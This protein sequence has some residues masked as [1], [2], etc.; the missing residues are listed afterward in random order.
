LEA[1][2]QSTGGYNLDESR[3]RL[4]DTG[5]GVDKAVKSRER[6]SVERG[7]ST[8]ATPSEGYRL[9]LSLSDDLPQ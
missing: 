8:Q 4:D 2:I 6:E 7:D 3:T 9:S 5:T 1:R